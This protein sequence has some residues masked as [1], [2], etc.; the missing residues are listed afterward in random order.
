M[1]VASIW[2]PLESVALTVLSNLYGQ[3]YSLSDV[4]LESNTLLYPLFRLGMIARTPGFGAYA[5]LADISRLT[6]APMFLLRTSL[7]YHWAQ[8]LR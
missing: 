1:I 5:A 7:P 4:T 8:I 6:Q 2:Y 3:R